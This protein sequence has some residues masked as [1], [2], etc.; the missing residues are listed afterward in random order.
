MPRQRGWINEGVRKTFQSIKNY[1]LKSFI[2]VL[3]IDF[4]KTYAQIDLP[5]LSSSLLKFPW[6]WL[7]NL[8]MLRYSWCCYNLTN[9]WLFFVEVILISSWIN[10]ALLTMITILWTGTRNTGSWFGISPN[11]SSSP[12][13]SRQNSP[14]AIPGKKPPTL[15]KDTWPKTWQEPIACEIR[16]AKP[17]SVNFVRSR[18]LCI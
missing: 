10:Q 3:K 6:K 8:Q 14:I 15:T 7:Q 5:K 11:I 18:A 13:L 17:P 4:L 12:S 1:I 2:L 16:L 9:P